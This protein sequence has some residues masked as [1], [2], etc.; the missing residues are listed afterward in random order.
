M[1][2]SNLGLRGPRCTRKPL[3][4]K[5]RVGRGKGVV[6]ILYSLSYL[7]KRFI[8]LSF[9]FL[10]K[11]NKPLE[12]TPILKETHKAKWVECL[13]FSTNESENYII[14]KLCTKQI[15]RLLT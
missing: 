10:A 13:L 8:F 3:E 7:R 12:T 2:N 14:I 6:G 11:T 9:F 1:H 4:P 15:L 5:N